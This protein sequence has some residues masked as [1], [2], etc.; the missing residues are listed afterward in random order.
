MDQQGPARRRTTAGSDGPPSPPPATEHTVTSDEAGIFDS[1]PLGG[2][3][4][5]S[6]TFLD[7]GTYAY[8]CSIH[9]SM[10]GTV[11]VT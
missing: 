6:F 11:Q 9:T 8:H 7:P 4:T 1:G 3:A 5:F 2:E 10:T